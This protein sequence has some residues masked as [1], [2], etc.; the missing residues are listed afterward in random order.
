MTGSVGSAG[1]FTTDCALVVR[2]W[3]RWMAEASGIA[4]DEVRGHRL[5]ELFPGLEPAPGAGEAEGDF[6]LDDIP[7]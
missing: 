3:D 7:F 5:E 4:E 1:S 2:S 6:D